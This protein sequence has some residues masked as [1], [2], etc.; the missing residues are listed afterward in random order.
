MKALPYQSC[1]RI[2]VNSLAFSA[3]PT[4]LQGQEAKQIHYPS[5]GNPPPPPQRTKAI[6]HSSYGS[7]AKPFLIIHYLTAQKP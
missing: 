2:E 5:Q 3:S 4:Q 7:D 6:R 1:P